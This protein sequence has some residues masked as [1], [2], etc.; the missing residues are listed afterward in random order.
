LGTQTYL[1]ATPELLALAGNRMRHWYMYSRKAGN[2][3]ES[4]KAKH[5]IDLSSELF[6]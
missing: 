1:S 2:P 3:H 4:E 5:F 6:P